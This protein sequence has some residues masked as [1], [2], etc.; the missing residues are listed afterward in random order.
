MADADG[1]PEGTPLFVKTYWPAPKPRTTTNG[2]VSPAS[3]AAQAYARAA[4]ANEV[5]EMAGT[6]QGRRND[7]LNVAAFNLGQL[8][9]GGVLDRYEVVDGLREAALSTGL[10]PAEVDSTLASGMRAG[11]EQA[12]GVPEREEEPGPTVVGDTPSQQQDPPND[13]LM[14]VDWPAAYADETHE[15]WI[16]EPLIPARRLVALFSPPK[17]GKSLLMLEL[18]AAISQ[19][20]PVLGRVPEQRRVLYVDFENDL[21][22]D[23]VPRLRAM[24]HAA[25]DLDE[26][27]YLSFPS[28]PDLDT[29]MGGLVLLDK[30]DLW[31]IQLVVID[32]ISRAVGGEENVNDTW[33]SFYRHTGVH[34]KGRGIATVR[35]DHTGKDEA[36][37][38]RGGSA[39]YGDVDAVWAMTSAGDDKFRLECMAQ[40][41]P[42]TTKVL[43]VKRQLQPLHHEVEAGGLGPVWGEE[44]SSCV[45]ALDDLAV[46]DGTGF[47]DASKALRGV[48]KYPSTASPNA[49]DTNAVR[50][51][52]KERQGRGDTTH[53]GVRYDR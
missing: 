43:L 6:P 14:P 16:V 19:G 52:C 53:V 32:T 30:C 44:V 38:M 7:R 13:G 48:A 17:L 15:D 5:R 40:R 9:G 1:W 18:A 34:L 37:G 50:A 26:L 3:K 28:L 31:G 12:R 25:E 41:L 2:W 22:G 45:K 35:L 8:V 46:P 21:T 23:V 20:A 24:G 33:L 29:A 36:K 11:E 10:P 42:I 51:A 4:Y 27:K 39:K 49:F 47:P